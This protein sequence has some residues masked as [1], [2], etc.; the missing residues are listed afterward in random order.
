MVGTYLS[1]PALDAVE[2]IGP[3]KVPKLNAIFLGFTFRKVGAGDNP[4][5]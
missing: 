4:I 5:P 1:Q 3:S 2:L